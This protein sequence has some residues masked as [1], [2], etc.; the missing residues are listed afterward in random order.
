[1]REAGAVTLSRRAAWPLRIRVSKSP[2]GSVIAMVY[3]LPLPARLHDAGQSARRRELTQRKARELELAIYRAWPARDRASVANARRRRIARQLGKLEPSAEAVLG[4]QLVV[5]RHRLELGALGSVLLRHAGA[6]IVLLDRTLL[7]HL[8]LRPQFT[9]G[10]SKPRRSALAS[11]SVF[12][13]VQMMMSM[14]RTMSTLS[15]SISGNTI[16][17]LRPMA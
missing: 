17:S 10:K 3:G 15:Y 1:M 13:V 14:P 6:P 11:A 16:C 2:T 8:V 5:H 7:G 9:N 4:A 12:A